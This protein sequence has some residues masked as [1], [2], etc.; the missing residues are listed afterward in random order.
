M[1]VNPDAPH[2]A[3]FG[4]ISDLVL[5]LSVVLVAVAGG[6]VSGGESDPW[7]SELTKPAL[8]PPGYVFGIVWPILYV[9]IALAALRVRRKVRYIERAPT[10]FGIFFLQ[11]GFNGGWSFLF[12][13][14]HRP[15]WALIDIIGLWFILIAMI[16]H[17]GRHSRLAAWL[18]LPYFC[19]VSFATYL[20]ASIV[21]LNA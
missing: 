21:W 9:T 17:F 6:L 13:F 18:L 14:F 19:W 16:F 3:P 5:I 8:N 15:S 1:T 12:F 10:S 2:K 20:N 11:L 7:Y 4:W